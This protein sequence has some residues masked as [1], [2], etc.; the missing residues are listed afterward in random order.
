MRRYGHSQFITAEEYGR[1]VTAVHTANLTGL[2]LNAF[3]TISWTT[4]QI[5]DDA[6][7]ERAHTHFL[8]LMRHWLAGRRIPV[9]FVWVV[10]RGPK[11]GL[12]SH[13]LFHLPKGHT[14][15]FRAW[16]SAQALR[17]VSGK[18]PVVMEAEDGR[19]STVRFRREADDAVDFQ[20]R[21]FRYMMKGLDPNS[22]V[23][24]RADGTALP[25][26]EAHGLELEPQ[27]QIFFKRVGRSTSLATAA[28]NKVAGALG[29][30]KEIE[31]QCRPFS[32]D[33]L[34]RAELYPII[35]SLDV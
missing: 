13:Y 10:E 17:T 32:I 22:V 24:N 5:D 31:F 6:D 15:P 33:Y 9:A 11:I 2:V 7:I 26:W 19:V 4:L 29:G 21:Q 27:G 14:L 20:F 8:E 30:W 1:A 34:K 12:H 28:G 25:I 23:L 16:I 35:R 3:L 18:V